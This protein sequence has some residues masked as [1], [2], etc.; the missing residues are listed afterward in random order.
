MLVPLV[1]WTKEADARTWRP[2]HS[3]MLL[4]ILA[5]RAAAKS[6]GMAYLDGAPEDRSAGALVS[7]LL[8]Q[9]EIPAGAPLTVGEM[10]SLLQA[11]RRL[12]FRT[13]DTVVL[14]GWILSRSECRLCAL[15][16]LS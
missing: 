1:H 14:H 8:G 9:S 6:V 7:A 15:A 13:G 16:A 10:R 3:E 12:D 2:H 5:D 4:S 11:R